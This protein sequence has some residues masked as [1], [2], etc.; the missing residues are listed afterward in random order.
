[1]DWI[2]FLILIMTI[3][4]AVEKICKTILV[5]KEQPKIMTVK[6]NNFGDLYD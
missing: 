1:M 5:F 3:S 2:Q 4:W 6:P